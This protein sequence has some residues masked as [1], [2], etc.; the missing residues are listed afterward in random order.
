MNRLPWW[1]TVLLAI[2]S[3]Y[4]L[5]YGAQKILPQDHGL[6]GFLPLL[7]PLIAMGFLLLAAKQLYDDDPKAPEESDQD[8]DTG[9]NS[10]NT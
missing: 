8:D 9:K 1:G 4:S 10:D 3:Y 5:K 2:L 6:H 7:A